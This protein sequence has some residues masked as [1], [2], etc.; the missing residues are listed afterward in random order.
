MWDLPILIVAY[1]LLGGPICV[2]GAIPRLAN[3]TGAVDELCLR[4]GRANELRLA[5]QAPERLNGLGFRVQA[6]R[7]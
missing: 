1:V 3:H 4:L 5:F 7:V 2:Q 6:F